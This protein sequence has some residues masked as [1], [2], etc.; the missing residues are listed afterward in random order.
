M[1]LVD[2]SLWASDGARTIE[3][4]PV[5]ADAPFMLKVREFI[6][7]EGDMIEEVWSDENGVIRK[8][9]IPPYAIANMEESAR[10]FQEYIDRAISKYIVA[11]V[12]NLDSLLWSIYI[13]IWDGVHALD[14]GSNGEST[15]RF[16]KRRTIVANIYVQTHNERALLLNAPRLRLTCRSTGNP[17]RISG[18]DKLDIT[19]TADPWYKH[20]P[21]PPIII[22]QNECIVYTKRPRPL[23]KAVLTQLQTLVLANEKKHRFA[24]YLTAFIVLHSCSMITSRDVE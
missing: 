11:V 8:H 4:S 20:Q 21:M 7:V 24:I 13:Y 2:I 17:H 5:F 22:A 9:E 16:T 3:V 23:S 15:H 1:D 14:D 10:S 12:G 6:P 18:D 19:D